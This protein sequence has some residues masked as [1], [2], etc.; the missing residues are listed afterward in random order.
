VI[1]WGRVRKALSF[2]NAKIDDQN[3][4]IAKPARE[5]DKLPNN[6]LNPPEWAQEK[7]LEF[8]G[9]V[10]GPWARLAGDGARCCRFSPSLTR[11]ADRLHALW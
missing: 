8:P 9:S 6:W 1:R 2:E 7:V 10:D 5:L 3:A 11:F 4:A